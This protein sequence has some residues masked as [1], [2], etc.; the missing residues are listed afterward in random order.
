MNSKDPDRR[1]KIFPTFLETQIE[2]KYNKTYHQK[3]LSQKQVP[4][5]LQK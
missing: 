1:L 4:Q 2:K 3:I 5:V